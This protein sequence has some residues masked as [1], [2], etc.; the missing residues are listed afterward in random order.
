MNSSS[1]PSTR[2]P[3]TCMS[4]CRESPRTPSSAL[5]CASGCGSTLG[6]LGRLPRS[7]SAV[8]L[9]SSCFPRRARPAWSSTSVFRSPSRGR[10]NC[11]WSLPTCATSCLTRW[12]SSASPPRGPTRARHSGYARGAKTCAVSTSPGSASFRNTRRLSSTPHFSTPSLRCAPSGLPRSSG[13]W[14]VRAARP[15][16]YGALCSPN[17]CLARFFPCRCS[18]TNSA[19]PSSRSCRTSRRR[20]C[21]PGAPTA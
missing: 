18:P 6:G 5:P 3:G 14:Q 17:T 20:V 11:N 19:M 1:P 8:F 12:R 10:S 2:A 16:T 13:L 21:R 4:S 9:R 7:M 15:W